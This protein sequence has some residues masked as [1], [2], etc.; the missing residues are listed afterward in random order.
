MPEQA[1]EAPLDAARPIIDPHL[2]LWDIP[3][4]PGSLVSASRFLFDECQQT[5]NASGHNITHTV[6]VE[7]HTMY[8]RGGPPELKPVGE[9]E[10]ANG[11]AAMAE[12]GMY[13][14]RLLCHRIVGTA[15]L[16]LG[17]KVKPVL[18]AHMAAAGARFR[19]IRA[20][21]AYTEGGM[22]G[23][24]CDP[25]R[26]H[27]L[28]NAHFRAGARALQERDLSL[29]VFCFHTQ[30]GEL[31]DFADALP[32]LTII[33]DHIGTPESTGA[34]ADRETQARAEWS[35]AINDL[36]RRPNVHVKIGGMG[37]NVSAQIGS[38]SA[39]LSSEQLAAKWRPYI[40]TCIEAF[41]PARCMFES[42]FPPDKDSGSYGATWNAFK[43]VTHAHTEAEK[44]L[45][46]RGTAAKVY[47]IAL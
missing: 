37:M 31:A 12:S 24:Q 45:L 10:F 21:I 40:Q 3:Q 1:E 44:D 41:T 11:V 38:A 27:T 23:F 32:D 16:M 15:D 14:P 39:N 42:N 36:A 46:F 8:R 47:R 28:M 7:C 19:G 26:R 43:R 6:F 33:L 29:D 4:A 2:H 20:P 35:K 13:G 34:Y 25:E 30:L 5:L 22:F 18:D 17:A 9:T